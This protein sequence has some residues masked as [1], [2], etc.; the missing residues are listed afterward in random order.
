MLEK[1]DELGLTGKVI[2]PGFVEDQAEILKTLRRAHIFLFCHKTP[3]S[4]R[5]LIEALVSATPI[6]GYD[7]AYPRD[8]VAD[9]GGGKF[10]PIN[11][12]TALRDVVIG[13]ATDRLELE[14]LIA[15]AALAGQP[16]SDEDVFKHRSDLIKTYL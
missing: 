3:E 5:S 14:K 16:F 13:L 15:Q 2:T 8:L 4:P 1:V 11:D 6:V 7:S 9:H 10:A 12:T